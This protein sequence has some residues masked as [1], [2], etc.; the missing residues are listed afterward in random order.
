[1]RMKDTKLIYLAG[2]T[3]LDE[4]FVRGWREY[5][6]SRLEGET[7]NLSVLDPLDENEIDPNWESWERVEAR[8]RLI[9]QADLVLAELTHS[10]HSYLEVGFELK[11]AY[12]MGKEIVSWGDAH[13]GNDCVRYHATRQFSELDEALN[14][15]VGRWGN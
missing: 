13:T 15:V 3:N 7:T 1:M 14:W 5:A 12:L 9:V 8:F 2:A 6:K 11:D 4:A 10:T